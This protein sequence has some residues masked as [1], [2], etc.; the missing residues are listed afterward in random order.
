MPVAADPIT[1]KDLIAR[2][3]AEAAGAEA[4]YEKAARLIASAHEAEQKGDTRY[5]Q[6]AK[7]IV[8]LRRRVEAGETGVPHA[9][10]D[11]WVWFEQNFGNHPKTRKKAE[12]YL[13]H[14]NKGTDAQILAS[15]E[16]ERASN[17]HAQRDRRAKQAAAQASQG[18]A[19]TSL[20][21]G[22]GVREQGAAQDD[23]KA[24]VPAS[25]PP[26]T[27]KNIAAEN[28]GTDN[29]QTQEI[30]QSPPAATSPTSAKPPGAPSP[31]PQPSAPPLVER[32]L[33]PVC[34][35]RVLQMLGPDVQKQLKTVGLLPAD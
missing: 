30:A 19:S 5:V 20:T 10:R 15:I 3:K 28:R 11:W 17:A 22:D 18:A 32:R 29:K 25:A 31:A 1:T 2:Y 33:C 21:Q 13:K 23:A 34:T 27:S 6:A 26:E 14:G 8:E 7:D 24:T 4:A 35:A 12:R 9:T 16:A